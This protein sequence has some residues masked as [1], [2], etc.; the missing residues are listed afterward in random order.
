VSKTV[1]VVVPAYNEAGT[2]G[3]VVSGLC[4]VADEVV[5]VDDGSDDDTAAIA[6]EHGATV[7]TRRENRGY[8]ETLSEGVAHAA[9]AGADIVVTF[10]ADGQH[11]AADVQRVVAPIRDGT[12]SIVVGHRPEPARV[13]ERLFAAYARR[14]L[15]IDDPLSGFKAYDASVYEEVGYFDRCSSIGTHLMVAAAKRGH[16][17]DQVDIDI[18]ERDDEPRFGHLRA[19]WSMF[20]ALCR[21]VS[22]DLRTEVAGEP[23]SLR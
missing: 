4:A 6:R 8:D 9:G 17:I 10:D 13:A 1:T 7:I 2:I 5:V 20:V 19:N 12:A 22:F 14:R 15:G 16:A 18:D 11:S 23:S 3:G 21:I